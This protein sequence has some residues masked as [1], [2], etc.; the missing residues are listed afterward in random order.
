VLISEVLIAASVSLSASPCHSRTSCINFTLNFNR[1]R[2]S[3]IDVFLKA[4]WTAVLC[5]EFKLH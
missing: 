4:R 1:R 2:P 5:N 3:V